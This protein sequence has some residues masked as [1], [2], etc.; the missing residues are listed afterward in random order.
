MI[1]TTDDDNGNGGRIVAKWKSPYYKFWK[2]MRGHVQRLYKLRQ[3]AH[4]KNRSILCTDPDPEAQ[5]FHQYIMQLPVEHL[6]QP[7][8]VLRHKFRTNDI[9]EILVQEQTINPHHLHMLDNIWKQVQANKITIERAHD[10]LHQKD[11]SIAQFPEH[12]IFH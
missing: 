3:Q 12:P 6:T 7:I 2:H 8:P 9:P 4:W 10:I 11:I 1:E 5:A